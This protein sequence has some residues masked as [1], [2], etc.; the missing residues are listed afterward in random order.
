MNKE[1]IKSYL[2]DFLIILVVFLLGLFSNYYFKIN[3]LKENAYPTVILQESVCKDTL[4]IDC[5]KLYLDKHK[6]KFSHI[7]L[8]QAILESNNLK[9]RLS[10]TNNNIFG[11]R[12]AAQRFTFATNSHDYGNYAKYE[13]LEDC[14][15]D[16]KAWQIQNAFF[17]TTDNQ[18]FELLSKHYAE[19]PTYVSNLK[20]L[21]K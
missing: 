8:A 13:S 14:I 3:V 15:L 20:K 1:K 4:T 17:I 21:I 9:S 18:Y 12:V 19:S 5:V 2:K 16:Y 10:K 7:I 11:M 6:L